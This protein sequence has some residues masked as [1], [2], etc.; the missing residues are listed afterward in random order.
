MRDRS[1]G[2]ARVGWGGASQAHRCRDGLG[3]GRGRRT[4]QAV[5]TRAVERQRQR[6]ETTYRISGARVGLDRDHEL[7]GIVGAGFLGAGHCEVREGVLWVLALASVSGAA[8]LGRLVLEVEAKRRTFL[9]ARGPLASCDR[10][11]VRQPS[12]QKT[13]YCGACLPRNAPRAAVPIGSLQPLH[14]LC[15]TKGSLNRR[16]RC[17]KGA[18]VLHPRAVFAVAYSQ[19]T[20]TTA[21]GTAGC[22]LLLRSQAS[23]SPEKQKP[24]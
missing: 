4:T 17:P 12:P 6:R 13:R 22:C 15:S 10:Q 9:A 8:Q 18:L 1:I 24:L 11:R 3:R 5:H 14:A 19:C 16:R 20:T 21:A 23:V 2:R 7:A